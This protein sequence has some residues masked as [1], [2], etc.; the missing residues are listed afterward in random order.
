MTPVP[1]GSSLRGTV[2]PEQG[3]GCRL[4][5]A[6]WPRAHA[7][8]VTSAGALTTAGGPE[9]LE[10]APGCVTGPSSVVAGK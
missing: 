10:Q 3:E 6:A 1:T 9:E 2:L 7:A 4:N 8:S 5:A